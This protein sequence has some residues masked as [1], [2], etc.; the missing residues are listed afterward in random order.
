MN[1]IHK[2]LNTKPYTLPPVKRDETGFHS[3]D[4]YYIDVQYQDADASITDLLTRYH[5]W[6]IE[7]N[8]RLDS[9]LFPEEN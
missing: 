8:D 9:D 6:L 3:L 4:L 7:Q 5:A 2:I 1:I